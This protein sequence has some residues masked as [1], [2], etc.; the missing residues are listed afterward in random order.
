MPALR[1]RMLTVAAVVA[2]GVLM[3]GVAHAAPPV[4]DDF[5]TA[6]EI[7]ALPF[8]VQQ[9]LTDAKRAVDDP[10]T[11][12]GY[13]AHNSVWF[14]YIATE[15]GFVRLTT[16]GDDR[17]FKT[18]A[19]TGDRGALRYVQ[20]ACGSRTGD[21]M[22]VRAT[23][24]QAYHFMVNTAEDDTGG[25]VNLSVQRVAP[26][27]NDNFA[28]AQPVPSLPFSAPHPDFTLATYEPDEP[29]ASACHANETDPSVWFSY[30]PAQTQSV[31]G[32][33]RASDGPTLAVY[34]GTALHDLRSVGC[35]RAKS[36]GGTAFR[37]N[38]G[39]KYYLQL[40]GELRYTYPS[41]LE[42]SEALPLETRVGTGTSDERSVYETVSFHLEH[43][44]GYD[45]PVTTEWD[46]GDGTTAPPSTAT[47]GSHRYNADGDYTVTVRSTSADGRTS[48]DTT[49]VKVKTQDVGIAK[50]TVP[51][52][53]R[54]G[55][56][57][58][59][60][61][62]VSNTRYLEAG[63]TVTLY[64]H[65]GQWW[66]EV[67]KLKLDVPAHPTRTV[68]FPFAYTFTPQD[69][70]IGKVTFRA[71]VELPYPVEDARPMDNEVIAVATTVRPAAAQ[72]A[73][74]H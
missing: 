36:Y 24:G 68:N 56:Q 26:L 58:P 65:D 15:D 62:K 63:T 50:F 59:V 48:T 72:T 47:S 52:S 70:A 45:A 57:K 34:E 49:T 54:A 13:A 67:G 44:N 1:S 42:L 60:S 10:G 35:A 71:V 8:T 38:A 51:A 40:R 69:A 64:K 19:F 55:Q 39:T 61:V 17:E 29:V 66:Q 12:E 25:T 22:T 6:T 18:T 30:T 5:D 27:A 3:P 46:F 2:L 16:T 32:L 9:D 43:R 73:L 31:V 21:L 23:A 7:T 28:D 37:L 53:A 74:A 33:V 20:D 41:T 11:C 14:R 4:N